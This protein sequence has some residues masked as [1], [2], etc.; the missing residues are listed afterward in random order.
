MKRTGLKTGIWFGLL[1][2]MLFSATMSIAAVNDYDGDGATDIAI[3]WKDGGN[4]YIRKSSD[5][6]AINTQW[7]WGDTRLVP[8]DYDGDGR[9]DYGVFDP[10]TGTWYIRMANGTSRTRNWGWAETIP[11]QADYDHDG[12]TD[13][14]IYHPESGNWYILR[15]STGEGSIINWGW[16][17]AIPVAGDYDGDG[18]LDITVFDPGTGN[19]YSKRSSDGQAS[20]FNWGWADTE[21]VP[22]DYDGDG[23]D[24]A[25]VYH[26]ASGNWYIRT[27]SNSNLVIINWGWSTANAVP[28]DYDGDGATDI[29]IY[30]PGTDYWYIRYT[31]GSSL[32]IYW[33]YNNT[34]PTLP[35]YQVLQWYQQEENPTQKQIYVAMG[36]GITYGSG[37]TIGDPWPKRLENLLRKIVYNAAKSASR[38]VEYGVSRIDNVIR[39]YDPGYVLILYGTNDL[40]YGYNINE[41]INALRAMIRECHSNDVVAV[42]ATL[43]PVFSEGTAPSW[44]YDQ[45]NQQIRNLVAGENAVLADVARAFNGNR[46]L[47]MDDGLHPTPTGQQLIAATFYDALNSL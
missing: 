36:D 21:P 33:G 38:V 31:S 20:I 34:L 35:L 3:F 5:G 30:D 10:V 23:I 18:W 2:G 9:T 8:G 22:A 1:A 12:I 40:T 26:K 13:L 15:S 24:D 28:G 47:I 32:N 29:A 41:I 25:A 19:W 42:V 37:E 44:E 46:H 6:Q 4:W 39:D 17:D 14:A 11:V 16:K 27:S 45:L 7:G 43:P